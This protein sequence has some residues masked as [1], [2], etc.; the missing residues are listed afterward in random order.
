MAEDTNKKLGSQENEE[1]Q[2]DWEW[3]AQTPD[4]PIDTVE[5][6]S[7]DIP[8][9]AKAVEEAPVKEEKEPAHQPGCCE[10]CGEKLKNSP[11]EY[12]CNVCREKYLKVNYG[13][14]HIIL[15]VVMMFVA[16]IGIV[17]FASPS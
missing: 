2:K 12:Y 6:E 11:S 4:T 17:S 1:P 15:S 8:A 3:D 10:I 14:S 5:I 16:V 7:F 13:A 9:K